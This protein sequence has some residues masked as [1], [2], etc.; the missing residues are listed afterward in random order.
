MS[1]K[2]NYSF[3]RNNKL[4]EHL[5]RVKT[6]WRRAEVSF[7]WVEKNMATALAVHT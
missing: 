7:V 1:I 5:K 3:T 4:P 6:V 2:K